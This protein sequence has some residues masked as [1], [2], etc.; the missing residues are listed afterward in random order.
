MVNSWEQR[1][2]ERDLFTDRTL[3]ATKHFSYYEKY[4]Q[5]YKTM[6]WMRE[7]MPEEAVLIERVDDPAYAQNGRLSTGG[8]R[9]GILGW[10]HHQHQWRGRA[11]IAPM[12]MKERFYDKV[13]DEH[14]TSLQEAFKPLVGE[15]A[16]EM[17]EETDRLLR[18]SSQGKRL[19]ILH[20]YYPDAKL[21]DVY[22]AR[23]IMDKGQGDMARAPQN[24]MNM[25][26]VMGMMRDDVKT[27]YNSS[28][29]EEVKKLISFY[30]AD[31][32]AW[33]DFE[34][35]VYD[36]NA[37]NRFF[38][39]GFETVYDSTNPEFILEI[40]NGVRS[41]KPTKILRIPEEFKHAGGEAEQ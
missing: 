22:R 30:G 5:D 3:D 25:Y 10:G 20:E 19:D 29:K 1:S 24:D 18:M 31:Y 2:N 12:D 34:A 8:G 33:G 6:L 38:G 7:N 28:D 9:Q 39:W 26:I 11:K 17:T 4:R 14:F 41:N 27:I 13:K 21:M 32:I 15:P 36:R 23:R 16:K 37:G 35:Q 40:E